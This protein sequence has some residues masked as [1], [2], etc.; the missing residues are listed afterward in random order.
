MLI[1]DLADDWIV[2]GCTISLTQRYCFNTDRP[3]F[4][5]PSPQHGVVAWWRWYE[6]NV[7]RA[8]PIHH[9]IGFDL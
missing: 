7:L 1:T 2:D 8:Q 4:A 9:A 3:I 5:S 6:S